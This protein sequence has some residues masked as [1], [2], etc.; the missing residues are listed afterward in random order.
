MGGQ[1][2]FVKWSQEVSGKVEATERLV[3]S[4]ELKAFQRPRSLLNLRFT[5]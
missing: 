2:P 5:S 4:V 3:V 1:R